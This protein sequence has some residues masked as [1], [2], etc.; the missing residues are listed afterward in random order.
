MQLLHR[1]NCRADVRYAEQLFEQ[2]DADGSHVLEFNEF[3]L[4]SAEGCFGIEIQG[5]VKYWCVES[6]IQRVFGINWLAGRK[7]K[8]L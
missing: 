7:S 4:V 6:I 8:G 1:L 3:K 5:K 2:F